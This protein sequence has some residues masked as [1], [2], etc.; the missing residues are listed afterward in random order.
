MKN[1]KYLI[2]ILVCLT[3]VCAATTT[4]RNLAIVNSTINNTPI[5]QSTPSTGQFTN[6]AASTLT[7]AAI[8]NSTIGQSTALAGTFTSLHS[9]A[10]GGGGTICPQADNSGLFVASACPTIIG[11]VTNGFYMTQPV[12]LAGTPET[13][14]TEWV[15]TPTL[16]NNVTSTVTLPHSLPNGV[17]VST[18][19][20]NGGRVQTGNDQPVGANFSGQTAPISTVQVNT[21]STGVSAFC[22]VIGY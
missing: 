17:F 5:G 18:C 14:Y 4:Y 13:L 8:N 22:I 20:D 7:G 9:A 1:L 15:N 2:T 10:L 11:P 21:P 19:S 6:L 12:L 3:A 16:G